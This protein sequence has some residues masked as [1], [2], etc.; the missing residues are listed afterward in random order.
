MKTAADWLP[1][2]AC[3]SI[4]LLSAAPAAADDEADGELIELVVGLLRDNDKDIRALALEQVRTGAAGAAATEAFAGQLPRLAPEAQVALLSALA[5][6]G[7]GAARSQ[8]LETLAATK[9]DEVKIAATAAI[10]AL[11][12]PNDARL[13]V[14]I[15]KA[16]PTAQHSAARRSLIR[17]GGEAVS[18]LVAAELKTS[19]PRL[20]VGL[21]EI[22]AAR[23]GVETIPEI[24]A[25]A[26][27][28]DATV[29][30]AA[31]TALGQL[32]GPDDVSAM[33]RGVLAA[34]PGREREAAEK[35][36][37]FVCQRIAEPDR[38]AEP[39][40]AA[41]AELDEEDRLTLLSTLGRV[42]GPGALK[43][44]EATLA[45]P[46]AK[47]HELGLRALCN[48][49]DASIAPRLIELAET[50]ESRPNRIRAL[51]A[52]MRVAPLTDGRSDAER[53]ALLKR[54]MTM[55]GRDEERL[56]ALDRA[57]AIRTPESLRFIAPYMVQPACAEQACLSIVE[58]A[59]HRELREANK[60]EFHRA[61][62]KVIETSKDAVVIDRAKRYKNNQTWVRPAKSK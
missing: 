23:R 21:I 38:R 15:L 39:L 44:I 24:L 26:V 55:A 29:R 7:D 20:R 5:D 46:D 37:M 52:L 50:D 19:A 41:M 3:L 53:L 48:W 34:E 27:D 11:G 59:H 18:P 8:V 1:A 16:A 49:P 36:V 60:A 30:A 4:A 33:V 56:L 51:R 61:L 22:L 32:A 12:E 45:E 9:S 57:R 28:A 6:R 13:L 58:L 17:L 31:M 47:R 2:V 62:D 40:L 25:C 43:W 42:G 35:S 10:G 54:A 14:E